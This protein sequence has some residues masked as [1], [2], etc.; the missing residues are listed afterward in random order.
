MKRDE[1][2]LINT[3]VEQT[4]LVDTKNQ[5]KNSEI[6]DLSNYFEQKQ[7]ETFEQE[8]M[9]HTTKEQVLYGQYHKKT[10]CFSFDFKQD[11]KLDFPANWSF[12]SILYNKYL[13]QQ[14]SYVEI[15][16]KN[17]NDSFFLI[18]KDYFPE[19]E[20]IYLTN[21]KSL[22]YLIFSNDKGP[23]IKEFLDYYTN[24][25]SKYSQDYKKAA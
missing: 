20:S 15:S 6:K 18:F 13:N 17:D 3:L 8:L 5:K 25:N 22:T 1:K 12:L 7:A 10:H 11:L 24:Q 23:R 4:Y 21:Y 14:N 9:F 2:K 19:S 16:K